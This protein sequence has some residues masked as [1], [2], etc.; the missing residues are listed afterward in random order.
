MT[1]TR[2]G[3]LSRWELG[4]VGV[5]ILVIGALATQEVRTMRLRTARA[6]AGMVLTALRMH[7]DDV[8][9]PRPFGPVPREPGR[10]GGA[11]VA[12][13]GAPLDGFEPPVPTVRGA[14]ALRAGDPMRLEAWIDAD[15]DGHPAHYELPL[16]EG[17]LVQMT[18]DTVY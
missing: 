4:L 7:L 13:D 17:P 2:R 8:E 12:W 16:G 14:Y 3:L 1:P 18:P 6:E 10:L 9:T 5:L 11:G 15:G